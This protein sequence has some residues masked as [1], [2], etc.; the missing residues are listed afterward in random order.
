MGESG[1]RRSGA[2]SSLRLVMGNV[3]KHV[4]SGEQA[5]S[6]FPTTSLGI[7]SPGDQRLPCSFLQIHRGLP[8]GTLGASGK[9]TPYM[10][11]SPR[12]NSRC[13]C[14]V[15]ADRPGFRSIDKPVRIY[16]HVCISRAGNQVQMKIQT[17]TGRSALARQ[18]RRVRMDLPT[19]SATFP[20]L[21]KADR[22]KQIIGGGADMS[23]EVVKATA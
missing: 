18:D 23:R 10:S 19:S 21:H 9:V 15:P 4:A 3:L 20:E 13:S 6:L 11:R 22:A 14:S 16:Y 12:L 1:L 17:F 2:G 7:E 8:S 5:F